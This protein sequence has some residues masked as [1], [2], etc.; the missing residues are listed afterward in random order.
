MT[1]EDRNR[2]AKYV[3]DCW[4]CIFT[5]DTVAAAMMPIYVLHIRVIDNIYTY[6]A[7]HHNNISSSIMHMS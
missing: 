1:D 3:L 7:D 4:H 6:G 5:V 2:A